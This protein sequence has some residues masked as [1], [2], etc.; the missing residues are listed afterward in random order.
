[1]TPESHFANY[2]DDMVRMS[3]EQAIRVMRD[4]CDDAERGLNRP[5]AC[6]ASD[7][8]ARLSNGHR[9][10]MCHIESAVSSLATKITCLEVDLADRIAP[11]TAEESR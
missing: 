7:V 1:M 9:N 8:L 5:G 4:A 11:I 10:A 2:L 3:L 6:H